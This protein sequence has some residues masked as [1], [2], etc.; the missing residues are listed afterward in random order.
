MTNHSYTVGNSG[1]TED[2]IIALVVVCVIV[3]MTCVCVLSVQ[4][5][6]ITYSRIRTNSLLD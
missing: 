5:T 3:V 1:L 4:C 6:R 2:A